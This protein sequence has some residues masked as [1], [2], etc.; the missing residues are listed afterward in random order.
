MTTTT[1]PPKA[2]ETRD[3]AGVMHTLDADARAGRPR[4]G[5][6]S[7]RAETLIRIARDGAVLRRARSMAV[8][9]DCGGRSRPGV[10]G[11]CAAVGQCLMP[12]SRSTASNAFW[13]CTWTAPSRGASCCKNSAITSGSTR[14]AFTPVGDR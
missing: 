4:P 1:A 10:S 7:G 8:D 11:R 12:L 5:A 3:I 6:R 13:V 2:I 9:W 14:R